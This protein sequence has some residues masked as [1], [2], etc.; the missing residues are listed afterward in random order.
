MPAP[1]TEEKSEKD[2]EPTALPLPPRLA[3]IP[4]RGVFGTPPAPTPAK[5][6]GLIGFLGDAVLL[7]AP[8]GSTGSAKVGEEF[9]GMKVLATATNRVLIEHNG[10]KKEFTIFNGLG[11]TSLLTEG[12]AIDTSPEDSTSETP[13]TATD[14]DES[15]KPKPSSE[16][17][18]PNPDTSAA[19]PVDDDPP[20]Q[21][22]SRPAPTT[23]PKENR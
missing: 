8:S 22:T 16:S 5:P 17:T 21:P 14:A 2:A 3:A 7:R 4:E 11:S 1:I 15:A 10:E 9:Q 20:A 18:P 19:A 6:P 23:A 12:E 13:E